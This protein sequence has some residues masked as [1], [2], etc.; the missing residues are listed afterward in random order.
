MGTQPGIFGGKTAPDYETIPNLGKPKNSPGFFLSVPITRT[1]EI[2]AEGFLIKG[3]GNQLVSGAPDP[4]DAGVAFNPGDYMTT[5][6]QIK[7]VHIYLDDLLFPHKFPVA[8]LRFKSLWGVEWLGIH[9]VENTPL[10][11][12]PVIADN[13][14][15]LVVPTFGLAM[16]Y[17]VAKHVLFRVSTDGFAFP[18]KS[19]LG[20]AEGE[21]SYRRGSFEIIGGEKFLH[22]KT[23]PNTTTYVKGTL[24]GAFA[25]VRWHF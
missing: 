17:A 6:Y 4:Y 8:K 18:H 16:E 5:Q 24:I 10:A 13:S 20:E 14:S 12:S 22:F 7:D 11:T 19:V 25:G 21:L 3:T 15:N 9:N 2:K 1:G 23:S